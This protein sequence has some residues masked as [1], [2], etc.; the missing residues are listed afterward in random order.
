MADNRNMDALE[1]RLQDA[2][3]GMDHGSLGQPLCFC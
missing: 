2:S 3:S 1:A